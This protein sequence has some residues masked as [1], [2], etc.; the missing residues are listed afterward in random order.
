M[1]LSTAN[2]HWKNKNV[3]RWAKE[4]FEQELTSITI[5][6]DTEGESVSISEVR[7]V[8][9][10]VELGQRKS[11]LITIFDCRVDMRWKG[12]ASDGT[13][14]EGTVTVPEVSHEVTV[15]RLSNYAYEWTLSTASS[16]PV[17]SVFTLAKSRLPTALEVKFAEFANAIV[18]THG[19]DLTVSGEPSRSGT[20]MGIS[21]A[22]ASAPSTSVAAASVPTKPT[23]KA[24][25]KQSLDATTVSVKASFMAD[26]AGLFNILTNE[27]EI[28][29]WTHNSNDQSTAQ[30]G[31][32]FSLFGGNVKGTYVSLTPP[33]EVVQTWALQSPTW[34]DSHFA[35]LTIT[36][37]QSSDSTE[38]NFSLAGVPRA[39]EDEIRQNLERYYLYALRSI[40]LG[41]IL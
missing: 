39:L 31:G 7:E 28:R 9:G 35:K 25:P 6:G 4:W 37:A 5:Q 40:G 36:F 26:A 30:A 23:K 17:A 14:V 16:P 11:K 29:R 19:K 34:P 38:V 8:D 33:T 3:T 41:S 32:N 1:P 2:W 20:P 18:D 24:E 12:V 21:A 13:E 15:D 22:S 27:K 10:D